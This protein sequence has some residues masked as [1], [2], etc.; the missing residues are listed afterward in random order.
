VVDGG[1]GGVR[2]LLQQPLLLLF[3]VD[4][5]DNMWVSPSLL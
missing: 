5:C 3:F 1:L 4:A 2:E